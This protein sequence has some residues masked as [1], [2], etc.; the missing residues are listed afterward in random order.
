MTPVDEL[1]N[2]SMAKKGNE[3]NGFNRE[4]GNVF[5]GCCYDQVSKKS[6]RKFHTNG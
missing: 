1:K 3:R 2:A 4:A 6:P 5:C